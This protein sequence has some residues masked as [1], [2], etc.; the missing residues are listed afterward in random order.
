LPEHSLE[1]P[2]GLVTVRIDP[3]TGL[4]AGANNP[5][6]IFETFRSESVPQ[7]RTEDSTTTVV[8]DGSKTTSVSPDSGGVPEELF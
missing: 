7:R 5:E 4:L 6:G 8:I 3:E 1:Q 2:P